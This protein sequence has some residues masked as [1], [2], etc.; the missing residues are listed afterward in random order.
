MEIN[1]IEKYVLSSDKDHKLHG[2]I[3]CPEGEIK[4]FFQVVHDMA[5]YI[6]RYDK[7][8]RSMAE[9]GYLVFGYDHLGHGK[10][11]RDDSELGFIAY[12][13]GWEYLVDDVAVFANAV[14][15]DY[16]VHAPF[17]LMGHSVGSFIA[18]LAAE[19]YCMQDKLIIMGTGGPQPISGVGEAFLRGEKRI[20][21]SRFISEIAYSLMFGN[22]TT[23]FEQDDRFSWLSTIKEERDI[24]RND[25]FCNYFF[26]VSALIDLVKLSRMANRNEWF[27]S[28]VIK[29]PILLV[30]GKD[31]PVGD[32]GHG[33]KKVYDRLTDKDADVKFVLFKNCRHELLHDICADRVTE[34]I[35]DFCRS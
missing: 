15:A 32:Y 34:V 13:N 10:T 28:S 30:S 2:L 1:V 14:K 23:H 29:K 9:E 18:R 16:P 22:Y 4:G 11:A 8:C 20:H 24:Y 27:S 31:D 33:V 12:E 3:Y 17:F 26:T 19:K 21:G 7:F 25:K 6:G 5:E 35:K